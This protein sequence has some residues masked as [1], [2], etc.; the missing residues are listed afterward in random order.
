[1]AYCSRKFLLGVRLE[2]GQHP[3]NRVPAILIFHHVA[4]FSSQKK[5][6]RGNGLGPCREKSSDSP[7]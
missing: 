5:L 6:S 4:A 7:L 3:E 2:S 1:M